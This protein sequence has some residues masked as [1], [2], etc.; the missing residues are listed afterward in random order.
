MVMVPPAGMGEAGVNTMLTAPVVGRPPTLSAAIKV[1]DV[2]TVTCPP[3]AWEATP[4]NAF[5]AGERDA[6]AAIGS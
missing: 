5:V 1:S 3:S 2:S 6:L 4:E